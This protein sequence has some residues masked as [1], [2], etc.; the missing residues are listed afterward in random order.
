MTSP[1]DR[2]PAWRQAI[3]AEGRWILLHLWRLLVATGG[4]IRR[5]PWLTAGLLIATTGL[6]G[7]SLAF[8]AP[9][10]AW[11][12][13]QGET[14]TPLRLIARWFRT[15]GAFTDVLTWSVLLYVVGRVIRRDRW[16]RLGIACL[17]AAS[18]AGLVANLFR[19]TIG[20]ARPDANVG[21]YVAV[22]PTTDYSRQSMP[23]GHT[24]TT[25]AGGTV[26]LILAP[27]IG[28]VTTANAVLVGWSSGRLRRHW[29]SD[30]I[31]GFCLGLATAVLVGLAW[32]R[33]EQGGG[34]PS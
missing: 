19:P 18:L 29:P 25:A 7:L 14:D 34:W 32:R 27:P 10:D 28:I 2:R 8:D 22:G 21:P 23:S 11:L 6:G 15:F 20:R 30:I 26:L 5:R 24:T 12:L 4:E 17:L 9:A 3:E 16:R 33:L 31:A 1:A 13:A